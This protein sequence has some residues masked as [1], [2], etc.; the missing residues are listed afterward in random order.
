V[1]DWV[2]AYEKAVRDQKIR[3]EMSQ[4]KREQKFY[5]ARVNQSKQIAAMSERKKRK[6]GH[7]EEPVLRTFKQR[8]VKEGPLVA[9]EVLDKV[10]DTGN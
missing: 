10:L 4:S 3:T 7:V 8:V 2:S 1:T 6:R 5:A 9:Q